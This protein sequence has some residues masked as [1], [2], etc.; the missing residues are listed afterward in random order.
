MRSWV[1]SLVFVLGTALFG[2]AACGD[3]AVTRQP[4]KF[5]QHGGTG[6]KSSGNSGASGGTGN[7]IHLGDGGADGSTC[8]TS[9]AELDAD[10]GFVTD[11]KCG[12]VVECGD[13]ADGEVCGAE[14]PSQCG[15]ATSGS[16]GA[17]GGGG[18]GNCTA[19]SCE[20][21]NA[22][23]GFVTDSKCGG[24]VDCGSCDKGQ[25]CGF[26]GPNRCG[27]NDGGGS[28]TVDPATTCK[29]RGATCGHVADNC[30]NDLDC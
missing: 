1:G 28:C 21:L 3:A 9:C 11:T 22:D 23:C 5:G 10:C 16:G 25:T 4:E 8:P 13:C 19:S 30:G 6:G 17:G 14:T 29:G 18:S 20:D 27:D 24:V 12:G 26:G 7:V 15:K 2:A